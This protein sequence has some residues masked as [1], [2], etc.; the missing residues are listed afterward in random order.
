MAVMAGSISGEPFS[1]FLVAF[2]RDTRL[3]PHGSQPVM[4]KGWWTKAGLGLGV[5]HDTLAPAIA[6]NYATQIEFVKVPVCVTRL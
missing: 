5:S 2:Q 4:L 1:G 3:S 6:L